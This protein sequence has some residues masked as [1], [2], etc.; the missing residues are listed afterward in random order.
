MAFCFNCGMQLPE[1]AKFCLECGASVVSKGA[2]TQ[3]K[4]TQVYEGEIHKCPNCGETIDSF[5]T[6][7][8]ACGHE[9]RG[10]KSTSALKEFYSDFSKT[11]SIDHKINMIRVFPIPNAKEDILEFMIMASSNFNADAYITVTGKD[12]KLSDAWKIKFEQW[13]QKALLMFRADPDFSKIQEI[14][15]ASMQKINAAVKKQRIK[16]IINIA[17][18]NIAVL[19]GII[20]VIAAIV[21]DRTGGDA[22]VLE[23]TGF[24]VLIIASITLARKYVGFIDLAIGAANGLFCFLSG[25]FFSD[26][27]VA[28][29]SGGLILIIVAICVIK[30]IVPKN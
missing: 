3:F 26:S 20:V 6:N 24:G 17:V 27:S 11:E 8:P 4:R 21:V 19:A 9:I 18:R 29:L 5:V 15:D 30:K 13:Y 23:L 14:Y 10:A 22:S 7:C 2:G 28:K 25:V 1:G 16:T 12:K